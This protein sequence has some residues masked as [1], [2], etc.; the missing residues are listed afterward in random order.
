MTFVPAWPTPK[1]RKNE[2]TQ[3][4][5]AIEPRYNATEFARRGQELYERQV[6]PQMTAEEEGKFVAID[7]DTGTYEIDR[8]DYTATERLL[9][10]QTSAQI[11]LCR[12]GQGTAYRLGGYPARARV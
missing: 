11:W 9:Q 6:R 1:R 2:M 3:M 4:T 12:V 10:R 7:I 5:Q 8:D